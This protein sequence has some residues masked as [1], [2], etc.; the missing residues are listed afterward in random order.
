[1]SNENFDDIAHKLLHSADYQEIEE[2]HEDIKKLINLH[3]ALE[4]Q[5][6]EQA[7]ELNKWRSKWDIRVSHIGKLGRIIANQESQLEKANYLIDQLWEKEPERTEMLDLIQEYLKDSE[8][9][10]K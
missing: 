5:L 8:K 9:D 10:E 6:D 1:M 3:Q 7:K 2:V 4:T